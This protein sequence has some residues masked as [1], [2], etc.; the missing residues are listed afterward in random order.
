M[1]LLVTLRNEKAKLRDYIQGALMRELNPDYSKAL[2]PIPQSIVRPRQE[3]DG[4][5][6]R[7]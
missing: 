1:S 4:L 7:T 2:T 3:V 5:G 6:I